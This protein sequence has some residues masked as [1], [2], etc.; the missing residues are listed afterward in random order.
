MSDEIKEIPQHVRDMADKLKETATVEDNV[1]CHEDD[2]FKKHLPAEFKFKHVKSYEKHKSD[3]AA[4]V[5]LASGEIGN[6][7]MKKND[8]SEVNTMPV[9]MIYSKLS[10]D[11][12][13]SKKGT[14]KMT[15][16]EV[17][18]EKFGLMNSTY[19]TNIDRKTGSVGIV[20][21]H[22]CNEAKNM[23]GK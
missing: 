11:Q 19:T 14:S 4:A 20:K 16:E 8:Y 10:I 18:W 9:D 1:I 12:K 15:G 5:H 13:R 2:A 7:L 17:P 23:F 22:I 3:F 6:E 21:T